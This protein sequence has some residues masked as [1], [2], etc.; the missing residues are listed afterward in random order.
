MTIPFERPITPEWKQAVEARMLELDIN[1]R[2]LAHLVGT[3]PAAITYVLTRGKS[4]ALVPRIDAAL[5]T[6]GPPGVES[7]PPEVIAEVAALREA[8]DAI[9]ADIV[10]LESARATIE[11]RLAEAYEHR[12][13]L[14]IRIR[15]HRHG[16]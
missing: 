7:R 16:P 6:A 4:S 15:H 10:R 14:E 11:E 1:P 5:A 13:G 12:A 3:S 9:T 8:H 2:Q